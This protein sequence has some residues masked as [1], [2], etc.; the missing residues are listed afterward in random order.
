MKLASPEA[1]AYFAKHKVQVASTGNLGISIGMMSA[2]LGYQA[3]VQIGL[4]HIMYVLV[5]ECKGMVSS[6]R[7]VAASEN[8]MAEA[9]LGLRPSHKVVK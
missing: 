6:C 7:N 3:I 8:V 1:R 4:F 9:R 5:S 2:Y